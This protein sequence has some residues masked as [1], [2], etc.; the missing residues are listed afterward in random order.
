MPICGAVLRSNVG[1]HRFVIEVDAIFDASFNQAFAPVEKV[2]QVLRGRGLVGGGGDDVK[3]HEV[4]HFE[5]IDAI[6]GEFVRITRSS[7]AST[8]VIHVDEGEG[9]ARLHCLSQ[10]EHHRR[11]DVLRRNELSTRVH[12]CL[13]EIK[14]I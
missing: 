6:V 3:G 1:V 4:P 10:S 5:H 12:I 14:G 2:V 11:V 13:N 7:T 9:V 8:R